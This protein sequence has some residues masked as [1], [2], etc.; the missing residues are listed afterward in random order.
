MVHEADT[1]V[2]VG[3]PTSHDDRDGH[4]SVIPE[5]DSLI[6]E[7]LEEHERSLHTLI[8]EDGTLDDESDDSGWDDITDFLDDFLIGL[9]TGGTICSARCAGLCPS[10]SW[11]P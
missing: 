9:E 11:G 10:D 3:N 4:V 7:L 1:L 8:D 5:E 6:D 2:H